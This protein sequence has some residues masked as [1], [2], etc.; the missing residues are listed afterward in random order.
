MYLSV[1][2]LDPALIRPG[3]VDYK[4]HI[5]Y[6][7]Q[8]QLRHMFYRFYPELDIS[9]AEEFA[10]RAEDF[11]RPISIAAVQGFFMMHKSDGYAVLKNLEGLWS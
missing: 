5:G 4:A 6:A 2:R 11:K 8:H 7:T 3:R 1:Y 9:A 10:R